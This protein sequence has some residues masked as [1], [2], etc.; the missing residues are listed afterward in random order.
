M[1]LQTHAQLYLHIRHTWY[2]SPYPHPEDRRGYT[3]REMYDEWAYMDA[4]K[5]APKPVSPKRSRAKSI[6]QS[7]AVEKVVQVTQ[8]DVLEVPPL[9]RRTQSVNV[10]SL[11]RPEVEKLRTEW[12]FSRREVEELFSPSG[13]S[14]LQQ[15]ASSSQETNTPQLQRATTMYMQATSYSLTCSKLLDQTNDIIGLLDTLSVSFLKV[16]NDTEKFQ[17]ECN[18]L[19][20]EQTHLET[21]IGNLQQNLDMFTRIESVQRQVT[22]GSHNFIKT[23]AFRSILQQIDESL[24]YIPEHNNFKGAE[25]YEQRFMA[26]LVRCLRLVVV[27]FGNKVTDI[28]AEAQEKMAT[29]SSSAASH[30]LMYSKFEQATNL[31]EMV[32]EVS[33]RAQYPQIEPMMQELYQKYFAARQPI[34]RPHIDKSV[35]DI[36]SSS[37]TDS[38]KFCRK[39]L[40]LYKQIFSDEKRLFD[41]FFPDEGHGRLAEWMDGL[42]EGLYDQL[43]TRIL[44]D[45]SVSVLCEIAVIL[46]DD[47][48]M[49]D[50]G[51]GNLVFN[52]LQDVQ[53]RL[54]FRAQNIID[55]EIVNYVPG[56]G[57]FLIGSRR[58]NEKEDDKTASSS[59]GDE[60]NADISN[61]L[62]QGWYPPLRRTVILLS[63]IYQLVNS[64][65]FDTMAHNVLHDCITSL[66]VARVVAQKRLGPS[67][68][69]LW[70]IK[71]LLMLNS[72]VAEFDIQFVPEE[73]QLDFSGALG[74]LG[75][76]ARERRVTTDKDGIAG[77]ARASLP[78]V[79]N[80]MMDARVELSANLRNAISTMTESEV[81]HIAKSIM[82]DPKPENIVTDTRQLREDTASEIPRS[83]TKIKS[84]VDDAQAADVLIEAIQDLLV[85]NYDEY[86]RKMVTRGKPEQL[87]ALMEVD[88]FVSWVGDVIQKLYISEQ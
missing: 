78:R 34:L 58:T 8:T 55:H 40:S 66:N 15:S 33:K 88:G 36:N 18:A 46:Q 57:D 60:S 24:V 16:E 72:Q 10:G 42:F 79:I 80:S 35:F 47:E 86:H 73:K 51:F 62:L 53:S 28:G 32:S 44:R 17:R 11:E 13:N 21:L 39:A 23:P 29:V 20:D 4:A 19:M 31:G 70:F 76:I 3:A 14:S 22:G 38:V 52:A 87:E 67:D 54:V 45:R 68:A 83:Y 65:V 6:I 84:Y 41:H 30:A 26:L 61:D 12:P 48:S 63:Q 49:D 56:D 74:I 71:N 50:D 82:T 5:P 1:S 59:V 75:Q 81:R 85:R 64:H 69:E 2:S 77:L 9:R 43:R 25:D 27:Y 7:V 37:G